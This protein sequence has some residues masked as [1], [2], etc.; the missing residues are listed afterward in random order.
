M[1]M[2]AHYFSTGSPYLQCAEQGCSKKEWMFASRVFLMVPWAAPWITC[3][4]HSNP[5]QQTIVIF[6]LGS[7]LTF[8]AAVP[9][10]FTNI[11]VLIFMP[12]TWTCNNSTSLIIKY[13]AGKEVKNIPICI[14]RWRHGSLVFSTPRLLHSAGAAQAPAFCQHSSCAFLGTWWCPSLPVLLEFCLAKVGRGYSFSRGQGG[15]FRPFWGLKIGC[16]DALRWY[17]PAMILLM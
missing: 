2:P 14:P 1:Y 5:T 10:C 16:W 15:F 6:L 12:F 9:K 8:I 17:D 7:P 11:K 3:T 13:N 4:H